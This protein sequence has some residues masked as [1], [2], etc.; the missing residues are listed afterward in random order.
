MD[1]LLL[2]NSATFLYPLDVIV[3]C[4]QDNKKVNLLWFAGGENYFLPVKTNAP[5]G[6]LVQLFQT[7]FE[8]RTLST[9]NALIR[10]SRQHTELSIGW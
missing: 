3:K 6:I 7:C 5:I 10:K 9:L 4:A 8:L 1:L 2:V